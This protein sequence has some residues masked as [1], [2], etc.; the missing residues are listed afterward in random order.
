ML[1]DLEWWLANDRK[2]GA[3]VVEE[4]E[5]AIEHPKAGPGRPKRLGGLPGVWSRR[6]T[7]HHRLF[8]IVHD[9]GIHFVSCKDHELP[10]HIYDDVRAGQWAPPEVAVG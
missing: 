6:I 1:T 4:I 9:V 2:T 8:Y 3:G 7:R 10:Q 5:L